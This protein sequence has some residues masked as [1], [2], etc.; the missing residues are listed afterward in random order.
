MDADAIRHIEKRHGPNGEHD[1]CMQDREDIAKICY[2]LSN[3]DSIT[4]TEN[5]S[6]KYKTKDNKPAPHI[7]ITK[8]MDDT[9]YIIEAASDAKSKENH[10][11]SMYKQE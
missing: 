2:I 9:Y 10:I 6:P 11:V 8:R 4:L 5:K 1:N 3:Y 7:M